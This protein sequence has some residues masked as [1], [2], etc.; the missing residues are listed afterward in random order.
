MIGI[1]LAYTVYPPFIWLSV[2]VA[3]GMI[4]SGFTN[5][6]GL[7]LLISELPWNKESRP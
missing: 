7:F 6:C 1:G 3:L 2:V 5:N 4:V